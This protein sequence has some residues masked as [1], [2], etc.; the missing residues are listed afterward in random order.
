[1]TLHNVPRLS[2]YFLHSARMQAHFAAQV[3]AASRMTVDL[4]RIPTSAFPTPARRPKYSVLDTTKF[5]KTFGM[6]APSW[7]AGLADVI[8]ELDEKERDAA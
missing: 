7:K 5:T 6:S 2:F 4:T 3:F 8:R 1:M